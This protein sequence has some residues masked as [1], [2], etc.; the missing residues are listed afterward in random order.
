M[1][2]PSAGTSMSADIKI[3]AGIASGLGYGDRF[4][5]RRAT[6]RRW[7]AT[8]PSG[9]AEAVATDRAGVR[10]GDAAEL[11]QVSHKRCDRTYVMELVRGQ[12]EAR[13]RP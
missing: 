1:A 11:S 7:A 3:V 13:M 8:G 12:E 9:H 4:T 6:R 5:F 2:G 10:S